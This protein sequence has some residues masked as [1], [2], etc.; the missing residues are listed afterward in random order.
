MVLTKATACIATRSLTAPGTD[1][2]VVAQLKFK[3]HL[4]LGTRAARPQTVARH[5]FEENAFALHAQMRARAPA[6]LV[7]NGLTQSE[8]SN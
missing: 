7:A 6:F 2:M 4:L 5:T 1:L 3:S 8:I